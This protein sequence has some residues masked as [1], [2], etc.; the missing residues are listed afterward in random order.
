ML[1]ASAS[2]G[3]AS[4]HAPLA[5]CQPQHEVLVVLQGAWRI[6]RRL[7]ISAREAP[8][9]PAAAAA[10]PLAAAIPVP[11]AFRW[12]VGIGIRVSIPTAERA[13]ARCGYGF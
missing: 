11:S 13:G 4:C 5:A 6:N 10:P 8:A 12:T 2:A 3:S 1:H 7:P 9:S